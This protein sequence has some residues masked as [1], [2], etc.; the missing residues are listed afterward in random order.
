VANKKPRTPPPPR[1]V[2]AP[3]QRHAPRQGLT[4]DRKRT[5]LYAVAVG[6]AVALAIVLIV[7]LAGN[8]TSSS[9]VASGASDPKVKQALLAAGC[10]FTSKPVLKPKTSNFHSDVPKITS[11]VKWS[12]FPPS[13]GAH[14]AAWA[15]WNFY[16]D[17][18]PPQ[19]A[20]HNL[21][22][23]GVVIWWGP[24]VPDST[25]SR[26]R[27]FYNESPTGMLGTPLAGLGN[28]VAL[29]AWVGDPSRYYKDGYYGIGK[30]AVCPSFSEKAFETFRDTYRGH[31]PEGVPLSS[32]QQGTGPF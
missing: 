16:T 21:E 23:G 12:T 29:S 22:H 18:V 20:V 11:K 5:I 25:V 15:I 32:D 14:Y 26:L 17:S 3:K 19:Q 1:K 7:V 28:K 9:K 13:G 8:K 10:T 30:L 4:A 27:D 6:G 2:Q 31:G 24:K